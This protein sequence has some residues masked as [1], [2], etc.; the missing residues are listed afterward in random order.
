VFAR[1]VAI[2]ALAL[3]AFV[4]LGGRG[5]SHDDADHVFANGMQR[6][7]SLVDVR[8]HDVISSQLQDSTNAGK[9]F[10]NNF[11]GFVR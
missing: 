3:A 10:A 11:G 1:L 8:A 6:M 2:T 4:A 5:A 7:Q 9:D